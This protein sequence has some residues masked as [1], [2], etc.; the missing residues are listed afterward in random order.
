MRDF[1]TEPDEQLCIHGENLAKHLLHEIAQPVVVTKFVCQLPACHKC[2][3]RT[4]QLRHAVDTQSASQSNI[5]TANLAFSKAS[6]I[7]ANVYSV[8]GEKGVS[9][10]LSQSGIIISLAYKPL[11]ATYS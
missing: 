7:F 3:T 10:Q 9:T 5:S 8:V 11:P 4:R 2:F 6:L 1:H